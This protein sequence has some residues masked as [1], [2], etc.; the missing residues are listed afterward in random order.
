MSS[1]DEPKEGYVRLYRPNGLNSGLFYEDIPMQQ[2]V[3]MCKI[4]DSYENRSVDV[5]YVYYYLNSWDESGM[6]YWEKP[7]WERAFYVGL[8]M[9]EDSTNK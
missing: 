4:W 5:N 1:N 6:K 2:F 9:N 3:E 8:L 7:N